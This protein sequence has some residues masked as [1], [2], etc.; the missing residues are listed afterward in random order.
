[1]KPPENYAQTPTGLLF[2]AD[3][4][5]P[6]LFWDGSSASAQTV[7]LAAPAAAPALS[8]NGTGT[9]TGTYYAYVR[10]LDAYGNPSD[11]SPQS[12]P[13]TFAS[14]SGAQYS[15]VPVPA[16]PRVVRRQVLRNTSG[17]ATT[18]YVDVDTTDL[19]TTG[20]LST[21]DDT[22]LS[23][24]EAVPLFDTDGSLLANLNGVP[25]AHK[26]AVACHLGRMFAS[27]ERDYT[28]GCVQVTNGSTAVKG[29]N[30]EWTDS[31]A[32]R[33]LHVVGAGRPYEI[34]SVDAANQA[35][36]LLAPYADATNNQ[37][38]YAV[39]PQPAERRLVY[40]TNPANLMGWPA[41]YAFEV[42]EDG[43]EIT[44]L[45]QMGSF[46]YILE[47]RH[48][49]RYTFQQDPAKDGFSFL[50]AQRG[51]VNQRCWAVVDGTCYMLDHAG[52]H[53]FDGGED[54][55]PVSGPIQQLFMP[56]GNDPGQKINW[57]AS[58][59]FHCVYSPAESVVRWFVALSGEYLPRHALCYQYRDKRWWVEE[60][61]RPVGSS[62]Q[63]SYEGSRRVF[64]GSS[65]GKTLL[66]GAGP[67]DGPDPDAGTCASAVT[68]ASA[69]R[70]TDD[71]AQFPAAGLVN[72]PVVLTSGRGRGQRR[73]VY[74]VSGTTLFL[75]EPWSVVP[76]PGDTYQVGGVPWAY[77]SGWFR[78]RDTEEDET[79]RLE[80]LFEPTRSSA[81]FSVRLYRDF[82]DAPVV[83]K[84]TQPGRA[85]EGM[86][87]TAGSPDLLVDATRDGGLAS[88]RLN[89]H[90]ELF[91]DGWRYTSVEL[92]GCASR[93]PQSVYQIL[94][95]G[96]R[97]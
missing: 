51:C 64:L 67:L 22:T 27:A 96:A 41:F 68:S 75:R 34:A 73:T 33:N 48:V 89:G 47:K 80:L 37:A 6:M 39:R 83:W 78:W 9:I 45:M 20:F 18:F 84:R 43:D 14:N 46:L 10:Y 8:T 54:T 40:Y 95:E 61:P 52:V 31:L 88:Q 5:S 1:M 36:T 17:Q 87:A 49:Y 92:R 28:R 24:Q 55:D 21:K 77:R 85:T 29:V 81:T 3:G 71:A 58:E 56:Y 23:A 70:L 65:A 15:N 16:D 53:A 11:L 25:P 57:N 19:V 79:R 97:R 4:L 91:A 82:R 62:A 12:D 93:D 7:G 74:K 59:W 13:V 94:L 50:S 63:A 38:L 76:A 90:K 30:T 86:A 35:L 2:L 44:G 69:Y 72:W 32:G 42:Q 60:Y 66:Y 26:T